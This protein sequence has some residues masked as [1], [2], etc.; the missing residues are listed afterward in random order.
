MRGAKFF[1]I[2]W[3]EPKYKPEDASQNQAESAKLLPHR[4]ISTE[5]EDRKEVNTMFW[6]R[7]RRRYSREGPMVKSSIALAEDPSLIHSTH[8]VVH[9]CS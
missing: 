8:M 2:D 9:N 5:K 3:K 6:T 4:F 1:D 7:S